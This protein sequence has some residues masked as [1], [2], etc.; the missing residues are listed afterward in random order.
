MELGGHLMPRVTDVAKVR[1]TRK[2]ARRDAKDRRIESAKH[3][4]ALADEGAEHVKRV[5]H[6]LEAELERRRRA[7]A[8]EVH[9]KLERRADVAADDGLP[10]AIM[11]VNSE[12]HA[13][14]WDSCA[15]YSVAGSEWMQR[16]ERVR[17]PAPVDYVE[18]VGGFLLDVLGLWTFYMRSV[19]GQVAQSAA[20]I[21]L[22]RRRQAQ[23]EEA[24]VDD[25]VATMLQAGVIEE[26][27]DDW[28][29][30]VVLVR[31]KDG[32]VFTTLDLRSG[33]WQISVAPE[34]RD[35]TT[36]TTK[37]GI[38]LVQLAAVLQ[39]LSSAGLTLKLKKCVF[40]TDTMEWA[41]DP[42]EVKRF[43]H[44]ASYYRK[45][46]EAF[47]SIMDLMTKLLKKDAEWQ[48]AEAHE[49]AFERVRA[50]L[51]MEP[52]L[53]Y[54]DFWLPFRLVTDASKV[55]LGA[56]LMQDQGRGWQPMAFA[57]KVNNNTEANYSITEL[58]CLAVVWAVK[59][60]CPY[61][62]GRM[63]KIITY[64]AA[65]KWLIT[66]PNL[67]GRLHRRSLTLQKYEFDIVYRSGATNVVADAF[68]RDVTSVLAA[69]C[70]KRKRRVQAESRRE[71]ES[72]T[73]ED[74][75]PAKGMATETE[76]ITVGAVG[77]PVAPVVAVEP[78]QIPE[79]AVMT[80]RG[81]LVGVGEAEVTR[82]N[83][84]R[85]VSPPTESSHPRTRLAKKREEAATTA[86]AAD[87]A[88]CAADQEATLLEITTESPTIPTSSAGQGDDSGALTVTEDVVHQGPQ[89]TA[90]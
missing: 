26:V 21:M 33:Y 19:F 77:T 76:Q 9:E 12:K 58:E 6:D 48:W 88:T 52:L 27:N 18:G 49:F 72:K 57:S 39:R 50:A 59:L 75:P 51:T 71:A 47:G 61:L 15:R 41:T 54:P 84:R 13:V 23:S 80:S 36:F 20:P 85:T 38:H 67:A 16:G 55:G 35:K 65:L 43:V 74:E 60:V 81:K 40:A 10:T 46:I 30:P 64:H 8:E 82:N 22:K 14:K 17:G 70:R 83:R 73:E 62:Y 63:F 53:I 11:N 44:L 24:V 90:T 79:V 25:N 34:D 66:R 28:G 42:I 32:E 37:A 87:V 89:P 68:S 1:M 86:R 45:F 7:Q 56:C 3:R 78:V 69:V 29:F 5:V 4:V 31:K 2:E